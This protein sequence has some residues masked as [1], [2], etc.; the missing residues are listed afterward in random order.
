M[1]AQGLRYVTSWSNE[2]RLKLQRRS[3]YDRILPRPSQLLMLTVH[4][5]SH[6]EYVALAT[7]V[8]NSFF[9]SLKNRTCLMT[10]SCLSLTVL[11]YLSQHSIRAVIY[12]H[13]VDWQCGWEE[14]CYSV[15]PL[16]NG[17]KPVSSTLPLPFPH[18]LV[19]WAV[20]RRDSM[21]RRNRGR[22]MYWMS[23]MKERR[24][25]AIIL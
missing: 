14:W 8:T 9:T 12:S 22:W 24:V 3:C 17:K 13:P 25:I 1:T 19:E 20:G 10:V 4:S 6:T 23:W 11:S 2:R 21:E 18:G 5:S 16:W 15:V 7:H